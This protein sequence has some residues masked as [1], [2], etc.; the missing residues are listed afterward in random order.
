MRFHVK[1]STAYAI[2]SN[3]RVHLHHH[4]ADSYSE[5]WTKKRISN[6][7]H[8]K[9]CSQQ[10]F[11][12]HRLWRF[13]IIVVQDSGIV[14]VNGP[15]AT[16]CHPPRALQN[17]IIQSISIHHTQPKPNDKNSI[18]TS[19]SSWASLSLE[20][21]VSTA[22]C[23]SSLCDEVNSYYDKKR[24]SQ[25]KKK[26]WKRN[27]LSSSVKAFQEDGMVP[28]NSLPTRYLKAN[29]SLDGFQKKKRRTDNVI[30][31]WRTNDEY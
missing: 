5:S 19:M 3:S 26:D 16:R 21:T 23:T 4:S 28:V 13:G 15:S 27:K 14:P 6:T 18:R 2:Q 8:K 24:S 22:C 29:F 20:V 7:K 17:N 1:N 30:E 25:K 31:V 11:G 10:K 9:N 12:T